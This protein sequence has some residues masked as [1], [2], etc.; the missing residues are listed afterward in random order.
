MPGEAR[1][2]GDA[3]PHVEIERQFLLRDVPASAVAGAERV[4]RILQGYL[5]TIPPAVRVRRLDDRML[6]TVKS[7]GT[8]MRDEVEIDVDRDVAARLFRMA[9][10][11]LIDKT[12]YVLGPWEIDVFHGRHAGV[13]VAEFEM[14]TPE[15]PLPD[16]PPGLEAVRELTHDRTFSNQILAQM[17]APAVQA[18]LTSLLNG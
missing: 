16:L 11:R 6:L 7:G 2:D 13:F 10:P 3:Y 12:R 1:S 15:D 8:L 4:H 9:G 14:R 18:M 5:T 17:D